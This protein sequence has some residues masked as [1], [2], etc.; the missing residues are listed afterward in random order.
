M[1]CVWWLNDLK[2]GSQIAL[3]GWLM[4]CWFGSAHWI[5]YYQTYSLSFDS[6]LNSRLNLY[7]TSHWPGMF[8]PCQHQPSGSCWSPVRTCW[9]TWPGPAWSLWMLGPPHWR[10]GSDLLPPHW[11]EPEPPGS[12]FHWMGTTAGRE[13][14]WGLQIATEQ[15]VPSGERLKNRTIKI[16]AIWD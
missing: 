7:F 3:S 4:H 16:C 14:E 12:S 10:T 5:K 15:W 1:S 2:K 11:A 13:E 9:W 6:Q 8:Q